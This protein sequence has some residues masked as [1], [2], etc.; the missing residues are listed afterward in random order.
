VVP[1]PLAWEDLA[2]IINATGSA[3]L[4]RGIMLTR[5]NLLSEAFMPSDPPGVTSE[6][7]LVSLLPFSFDYGL[8]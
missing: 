1:P 6:E 8:N 7:V 3:G 5:Q 2:M 4:P